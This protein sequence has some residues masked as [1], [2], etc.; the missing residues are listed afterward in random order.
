MPGMPGLSTEIDDLAPPRPQ[1]IR[2]CGASECRFIAREGGRHCKQHHAEAVQRWR[3]RNRKEI[4]FNRRAAEKEATE[5][6][7]ALHIARA[8]LAVYIARGKITREPCATC[9]TSDV[10]AYI[11]DAAKW[12]EPVWL[13]RECRDAT[14]QTMEDE[15]RRLR[16]RDE[17]AMRRERALAAF[18]AL[19]VEQ[20]NAIRERAARGPLGLTLS[21]ESPLYQQ[22]LVAEAEAILPQASA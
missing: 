19:S 4:N 9:Y 17:Y 14:I 20:Q 11:A 12:R 6:E 13:C 1:F 5:E 10:T 16:E 8:K 15:T 3:N 2:F 22:R 7:R 18:A 21:P